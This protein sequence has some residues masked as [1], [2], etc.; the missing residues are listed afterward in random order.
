MLRPGD[1]EINIHVTYEDET[2]EVKSR[3]A[4]LTQ[5]LQARTHGGEQ[6][7]VQTKRE[8]PEGGSAS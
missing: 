8:G 5:K 6:Q 7:E 3:I 4:A 2:A 1:Q